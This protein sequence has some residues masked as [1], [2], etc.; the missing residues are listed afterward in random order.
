MSDG[1]RPASSSAW[2][3]TSAWAVGLGTIQPLVRPALM[4]AVPDTRAWTRSPA[5]S[6]ADSG[7]RRR[8][9]T[10]SAGTMPSPPRPKLRHR[11]S[12]EAPPSRSIWRNLLGCSDRLVAATTAASH[13]PAR[14]A[15]AARCRA[16]SDAEHMVSTVMLGPCR[17]K[18]YDTRLAIPATVE[19]LSA[20]GPSR[21]CS[22]P[23]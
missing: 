22:T 20:A 10:A 23:K 21:L 17:S 3:T 4:T 1:S 6:A 12:P 18:A 5:A 16:T 2:R 9:Q 7:L 14:R 8:A 19:P 15:R 11:W 13:S